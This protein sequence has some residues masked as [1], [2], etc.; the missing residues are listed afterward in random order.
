[1][2]QTGYMLRRATLDDIPALVDLQAL[3]FTEMENEHA[4]RTS[5]RKPAAD[6][7]TER[8]RN[9]D[10]CAYV[11]EVDGSVAASAL[12]YLH[13]APPSPS[14]V[15]HLRGHISNVVTLADH[16]RQGYARRCVEALLEWFRDE[17]PVEVVD[18]SASN[19]G[20]ALYQSMGWRTREDP[21]MRR[22]VVRD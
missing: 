6:W 19:D 21:T 12:G 7:L 1:M 8:F 9:G 3:L 13:T 22:V 14:S 16:R 17:T 2:R 15:T 5:W 20:F 18:L 4:G 10:A 11:V